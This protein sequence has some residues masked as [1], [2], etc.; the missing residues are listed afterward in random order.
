MLRTP[1]KSLYMLFY[2]TLHTGTIFAFRAEMS[3][4]LSG[5]EN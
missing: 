1:P 5:R 3:V 4:E 2:L